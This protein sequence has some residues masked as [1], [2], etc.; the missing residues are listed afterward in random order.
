[1]EVKSAL[2]SLGLRENEAKA[3]LALLKLRVANPHTIAKEA[4]IE[5]TAIYTIMEELAEK[6][7]SNKIITGKRLSYEISS[8]ERFKEILNNQSVLLHELLPLL[9][10]LQGSKGNKPV[11]R[12]YNDLNG[13]RRV[14]VDS[15]NSQE[16]IRRDFASVD[17]ITE[18]L[19]KRFI[20]SQVE[21]RVKKKI[22]ARSLRCKRPDSESE[23]NWFL[24]QTNLDVLREVRYLP[25]AIQ[26]NPTI[27]IY[28][29]I[30]A[31]ISS[32]EESYALVIESREFSEAMKIL[33]D[34]A[35]ESAEK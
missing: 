24:K 21:A 34:I 25:K 1:M 17:V 30:V 11:V 13:M 23:K 18:T 22:Q 9:L 33:F 12:F 15:L 8:P 7:L 28:D 10:S 16:K 29:H 3:Y 6:G 26:F 20:Q 14:L 5:R 31:I 4:G 2:I 19:G 32:K 35:W 27:F